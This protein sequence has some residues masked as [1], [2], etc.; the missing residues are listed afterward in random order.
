MIDYQTL[1]NGV[2]F[3]KAVVDEFRGPTQISSMGSTFSTVAN[4]LYQIRNEFTKLSSV[5][6]S[7][8]SNLLESTA[9][10]QVQKE[11]AELAAQCSK[12]ERKQRFLLS[13]IRD[14]GAPCIGCKK[15]KWTPHTSDCVWGMN[16][17]SVVDKLEEE[18]DGGAKD[19]QRPG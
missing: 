1:Q 19:A 16:L 2:A 13:L 15:V 3:L 11:N 18:L 12:L 9:I 14:L 7:I 4:E 6:N 10:L 5:A 8:G 17:E